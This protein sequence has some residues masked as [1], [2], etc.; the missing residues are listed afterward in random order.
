MSINN[1]SRRQF[2]RKGVTAGSAAFTLGFLGCSQLMTNPSVE[3][4]IEPYGG[5]RSDPA[6]V[7][8]LPLGFKYH[9][10]SKTGETMDDGFLVPGGHDGMAAFPGPNGRN[11][12]RPKPRTGNRRAHWSFRSCQRISWPDKQ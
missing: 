7:L 11:H 4:L 9:T 2:L 5:F 10:F 12:S 6:G 3:S 8:D 1:I